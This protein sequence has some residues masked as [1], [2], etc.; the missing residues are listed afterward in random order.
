MR[1]VVFPIVVL[2]IGAIAPNRVD[3]TIVITFAN[4]NTFEGDE[5]GDTA[6]PFTDTMTGLSGTIMTTSVLPDGVLNPNA[7]TLG[8]NAAATSGESSSDFDNGES[9]SFSWNVPTEFAGISF[10]GYLND[11]DEEFTVSSS[12]WTSLTPSTGTG[13]SFAAGTFT[14]AN[15]V[16]GDSF[17]ASSLGGPVS[18]S[19]GSAMTISF[20]S[21][22][23]TATVT[24][25]SFN[26]VPEASAFLFGTMIC[27]VI[28]LFYSGRSSRPEVS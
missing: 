26:I 28:G 25:L 4:G 22:G 2:C 24:S 6:G 15:N 11:S 5:A 23:G 10:G 14:F 8:I 1:H 21:G 16:S 13:V 12:E 3:A 7:G 19:M 27:G 20:A 17:D 18:L 9:W